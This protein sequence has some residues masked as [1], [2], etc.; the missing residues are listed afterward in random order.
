MLH[1]PFEIASHFDRFRFI[2]VSMYLDITKIMNLEMP[3]RLTIWNGGSNRF[4]WMLGKLIIII[5]TIIII[6]IIII[7]SFVFSVNHA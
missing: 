5:I 7:I 1:P 2:V 3:K 6:I 4:T